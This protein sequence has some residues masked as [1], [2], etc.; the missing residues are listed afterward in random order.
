MS[1]TCYL[2]CVFLSFLFL[3]WWMGFGV[4]CVANLVVYIVYLYYQTFRL[5]ILA[6]HHDVK[7]YLMAQKCIIFINNVVQ[8]LCSISPI[9]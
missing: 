7:L 2:H 6:C 9:S 5:H 4:L 8:G 1:C 3:L